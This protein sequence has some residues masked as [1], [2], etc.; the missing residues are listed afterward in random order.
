MYAFTGA[1]KPGPFVESL[2][3]SPMETL[4]KLHI[5]AAG[6]IRV[7]EGAKNRKG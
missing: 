7:E 2:D 4:D 3:I 6:Y 1:L 5:R